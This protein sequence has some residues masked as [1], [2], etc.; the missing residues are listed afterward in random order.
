MGCQERIRVNEEQNLRLNQQIAKTLTRL[1]HDA[2]RHRG[3]RLYHM[4]R[5]NIFVRIIVALLIV[6]GCF[7][8]Y[9]IIDSYE[10]MYNIVDNVTFL[11][12][13]VVK[14]SNHMI[15]VAQS[16]EH[17]NRHVTQMP[18]ITQSVVGIAEKLPQMNASVHDMLADISAINNEMN[19]LN[20]SFTT[21]N[22]NFG[23]ITNGIGVMSGNV[24][25]MSRPMGA[26]NGFMP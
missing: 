3:S 12:T 2:E 18:A 22:A 4:R 19:L 14:V 17:I 15:N 25:Q 5:T 16:M 13:K 10:E 1:E 24:H 26:M 7:N 8:V 11:D 6:L 21:V 20:A 23:N 9:Y